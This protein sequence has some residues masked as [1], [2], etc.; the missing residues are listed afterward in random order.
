[1]IIAI[2]RLASHRIR[3]SGGVP[4]VLFV[5]LGLGLFPVATTTTSV[6]FGRASSPVAA[7]RPAAVVR[8]SQPCHWEQQHQQQEQDR[9]QQADA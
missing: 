2:R 1:M 8:V 7:A 4:A 9:Q 6:R 3:G 5:G